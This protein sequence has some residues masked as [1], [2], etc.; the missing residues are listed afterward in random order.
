[1][2]DTPIHNCGLFSV[3]ACF[4]LAVSANLH[5][6][7]L[8]RMSTPTANM[9]PDQPNAETRSAKARLAVS[10]IMRVRFEVAT[11]PT[12]TPQGVCAIRARFTFKCTTSGRWGSFFSCKYCCDPDKHGDW[13]GHREKGWPKKGLSEKK[14]LCKTDE[15][16]LLRKRKQRRTRSALLVQRC[17]AQCVLLTCLY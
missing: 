16:N 7:V 6:N 9:D 13:A 2:W 4:Q 10:E 12:C 5:L 8:C 14:M 17:F 15:R 3:V 1:M 11:S